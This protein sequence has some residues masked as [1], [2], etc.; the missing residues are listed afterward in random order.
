[1]VVKRMTMF[2]LHDR[3]FTVDQFLKLIIHAREISEEAKKKHT[4]LMEEDLPIE[5]AVKYCDEFYK[6]QSSSDNMKMIRFKSDLFYLIDIIDWTKGGLNAR[7]N[8][9]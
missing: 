4:D 5:R 6:G 3:K 8:E 9:I 2:Q 1:M 7:R